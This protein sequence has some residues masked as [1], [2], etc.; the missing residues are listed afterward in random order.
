MAS[1][2]VPTLET[3]RVWQLSKMTPACVELL[4]QPPPKTQD[5]KRNQ[6]YKA[7]QVTVQHTTYSI[8]QH[9]PDIVNQNAKPALHAACFRPTTAG[10]PHSET[11]VKGKFDN[12]I[13]PA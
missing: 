9:Q 5:T 1:E 11:S 13:G 7:Q 8:I 2:K 4:C 6:T 3:G 10:T 12:T